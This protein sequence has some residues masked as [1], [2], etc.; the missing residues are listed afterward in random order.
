MNEITEF[1]GTVKFT[2]KYAK[3]GP[4]YIHGHWIKRH[5][6]KPYLVWCN[7]GLYKHGINE[8]FIEIVDIE[9]PAYPDR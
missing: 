2:P 7:D 1:T 8:N 4:L 5:I 3:C 9:K 6:G